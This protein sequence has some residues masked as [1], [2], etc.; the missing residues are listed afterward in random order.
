MDHKKRFISLKTKIIASTLIPVIIS[1]SLIG[2]ALFSSLFSALHETAKAEFLQ[3]GQKYAVSFEGKIN[4]A[5]NYLSIVASILELQVETGTANRETLQKEVLKIFD[6]YKFIDGSSIYFE[7]DMYDGRDA[8]YAGSEYGSATSGRI[9]YYFYTNDGK[10]TY[11]P[12]ALDNDIEFELPHYT[13]AKEANRPIYTEPVAYEVSGRNIPMF[14]LT[15]PVHDNAGAFI[16]AVT[17]DL[18]LEDIYTQLQNEKIY[19]TGYVI[20]A[21]DNGQVVY[22]PRYEDIGKTRKEAGLDY[23]LPS[24]DERTVFGSTKSI[25]NGKDTFITIE[26]IYIPQLDN[27]FYITVAAPTAE[28]NEGGTRTMAILVLFSLIIVVAIA[29]LLYYLIGKISSPV[30]EITESANKIANG[31]ME[32]FVLSGNDAR[33]MD[34]IHILSIAIKKMLSQINEMQQLKL[35][36]LELTHKKEKAEAAAQAKNDFL[37]KMSHEIRT[38]MNAVMGMSELIL[39]KELPQDVYENALGIKG[40]SANLLSIINDILDFSKIESGMLEIIETDYLLPSLINDVIGIIRIRLIEKPVQ[41][42]V[43][44]APGIPASLTGDEIR[45]RQILLNLLSNAVKYTGEG[46]ISMTVTGEIR[47][48]AVTLTIDISDSGI[49][50]RD[51]DV[52]KLFGDFVQIDTAANKGIEGTGLGLAISRKL[53]QAMGGDIAVRSEYGK[54]STFTVTLPQRFESYRP[55]ASI[56]DPGEKAILLY[57]TRPV[58][59]DSL[60]QAFESL[61]VPYKSVENIPSLFENL[62]EYPYVF[63]SSFMYGSVHPALIKLD[64]PPKLVLLAD[65]TEMIAPKDAR[66]LSLPTHSLS[67]ANILNDV[68]ED[69][70]AIQVIGASFTA[71]EI[72]VLVVDDIMANLKVA[73][74]LM[75][76][77]EMQIT[78]CT[79]GR[80][81]VGLVAEGRYDLVFMDHMMPEMDGLEAT[82]RI[83]EMEGEYFKSLPIIA[84]TANAVSGVREMFIQNG[85]NDFL[86]KPIETVKLDAVLEKWIPK[87]KQ[88]RIQAQKTCEEKNLFV[89]SLHGVHELDLD[90]A[91]AVVGGSAK[92]YERMV[93]VSVR[94]LPANIA[95]LDGLIGT[96]LP[97]YA[98]EVHGIKSVLNN[99]GAYKLGM[100]AARLEELSKSGDF[101]ACNEIHFEFIERLTEFSDSMSVLTDQAEPTDKPEGDRPFLLEI[102]PKLAEAADYFDSVL[103]LE[104]LAP[105]RGHTY[106]RKTDKTIADL[107]SAFERFDFDTAAELLGKIR[108]YL[109]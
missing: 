22:S 103:A 93:R 28:I 24:E 7:P 33:T 30:K 42:A 77:Y 86:A 76:P 62:R 41:F 31:D 104:I 9:C 69:Y 91:L 51:E 29:L 48:N 84:L 66:I 64:E 26:S 57:E 105:A 98:I 5:I 50:V 27:Y 59:R 6:D 1:L 88:K 72:R 53:C 108:K 101:D 60:T 70:G 12:E 2:A 89:D 54:G 99:I 8:E 45:V 47:D 68:Y 73:E 106:G 79:G 36:T 85:M 63:I 43:S 75:S 95:R 100:I 96:D 90:K 10:T 13:K 15:Y 81:A 97:S 56:G 71:P 20:I 34:E 17:V 67:I 65:V 52:S 4:N 18:F 25:L 49:G 107:E 80:E 11:L 58:Y 39:R 21:N 82:G 19:E 74:G 94:L 23:A 55:F 102:L 87:E 3:I 40:A 78:I 14:T 44:I 92:T 109:G 38:P 83:R 37:A 32:D 61:G 35:E 46:Y 16:G